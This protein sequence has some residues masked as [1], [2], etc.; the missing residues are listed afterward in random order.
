[1][2]PAHKKWAHLDWKWRFGEKTQCSVIEKVKPDR[3]RILFFEKNKTCPKWMVQT[4]LL[5]LS[6]TR[7]QMEPAHKKWAPLDW[8]WQFVDQNNA[9]WSKKWSLIERG[10]FFLEI[11]KTCPKSFVKSIF[12]SPT[13]AQM[14]PAHKNWAQLDWNWRFVKKKQCSVIEKVKP[15]RARIL[16]F[17][18]IKTCPKWMVQTIFLFYPQL[19]LKWSLPTKNELH[20]TEIDELLTK[21]MFGG[22]KR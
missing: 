19:G 15:D 9:R 22:R 14:E 12:L 6:P 10:Y 11:D 21:T 2:E 3:A 17:E 18:K 1:M 8:N 20:W 13:R 7:A 16:F 5:I 4:I